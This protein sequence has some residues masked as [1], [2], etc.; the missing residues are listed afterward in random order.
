M[1]CLKVPSTKVMVLPLGAMVSAQVVRCLP[2]C[3]LPST[4]V[5]SRDEPD[6]EGQPRA[7]SKR[8]VSSLAAPVPAPDLLG[9][10]ML[11]K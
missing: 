7:A 4:P 3:P 2:V 8:P 9:A 5:G 6:V 1:P 10:D 11:R